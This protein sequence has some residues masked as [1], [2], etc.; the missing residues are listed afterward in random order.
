MQ[1]GETNGAEGFSLGA[2]AQF[3]YYPGGII[4]QI[5]AI[6]HLIKRRNA[7]YWFFIIFFGGGIGAL[8]YIV[9]E[10]LPELSLLGE[11]FARRAR[12]TRIQHVETTILDNPSA[13]NL[14][15]LGELYWDERDIAKA[16]EAFDRS[17]AARSDSLHAFYRRGL[18]ALQM[19]DAAGAIPDLAHVV[20]KERHYDHYR[21]AALLAH[22]YALTGVNDAATAFFE[23]AV[24]V[25]T[26][27]ETLYNY[28]SFLKSQ[29]QTAEA[30]E[31]TEKLLQKKRTL[32]RA[33]A[34]REAPWFRKGQA[35]LKELG[36]S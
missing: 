34:R 35:L 22:A 11:I 9:I 3:L 2:L 30:R 26:T 32:P 24:Q 4:L 20:S 31:W 21:A 25:S 29:N 7:Y 13:A 27:P 5:L 12:K 17:I 8:I 1:T 18:C 15:E 10:V 36:P 28:A 14:E 19:G 33:I 23:E 16:R 6:V